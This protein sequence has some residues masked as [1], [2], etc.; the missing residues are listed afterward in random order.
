MIGRDKFL[1]KQTKLKIIVAVIFSIIGFFLSSYI[2][3]FLDLFLKREDIKLEKFKIGLVLQSIFGN[4][5]PFMLF[6]CFFLLFIIL[7]IMILMSKQNRMNYESAMRKITKD[8]KIPVSAGQKQHGSAEWLEKSQFG[9]TFKTYV[10]DPKND[11]RIQDLIDNGYSDLPFSKEE[12][13]RRGITDE[14]KK[15]F[16]SLKINQKFILKI[17]KYLCPKKTE[18]PK[19]GIILG[20]SKKGKREHIYFVDDDIHS[21]CIGAT[22][23]GKTRTV[24][25]QSI[26]LQALAGESMINSDPKSELFQYT[27]PFLERL[28]YEVITI[29]FKNPLKSTRYNFLQN[30]IDAVN[31]NDM[32]KAIDAAWDITTS[33]VGE[34]KGER[35]WT[36]GEASIIAASILCVVVDN[37]NKPEFQNMS[38]VYYFISE[39]CKPQKDNVPLNKYMKKLD[40]DHPARAL[41]G[42]SEVAPS[43]TRG[44]FFTAALTTLRLFTNPLIYSMT[45]KTDFDKNKTG[46]NKRAIFIILPDEKE[47]YYTLASLFISQHYE[48]LVQIADKNGGR[49]KR[50]VNFNV[51]EFGNFAVIPAFGSKLTVGGGRGIR[52]NLFLQSFAQLSEKYGEHIPK[53]IKANCQCWI[54]LKSDDLETLEE[55]SKKLGNYTVSTNSM[56]SS[57]TSGQN[58]SISAS[59]NLT[60][61]PLL[62]SEEV[63][64]IARPYSLVTTNAKPA[65]LNAPDISEYYFNQMYGLG[66]PEFN[67][68]V[69]IEREKRRPE[70][71][72][73]IKINLWGIWNLYNGAINEYYNS[74]T[75]G[76]FDEE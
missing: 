72:N 56:S 75:E 55:I 4:Q 66:S 2:S 11:F 12:K 13:S 30:V 43:R 15:Y 16:S 32:P 38:N 68:R 44:S 34:S 65:I 49:L 33:L 50:R 42:I 19:G 29:D 61:R 53:T 17:P 69:R 70:R 74:E 8:I 37:K 7:M 47:T 21:L 63:K 46:I 57:Y 64:M 6:L 24:V 62:T 40:A 51:D 18:N 54:Y 58:G 31:D 10:I 71:N 26:A 67:L 73:D 1:K 23:S 25:L 27:Y 41:L 35:I 39:M 9:K 60:A 76:E 5:K 36:D 48:S 3:Y 59:F 14:I 22:R 45:C 52:F 28:G 20:V